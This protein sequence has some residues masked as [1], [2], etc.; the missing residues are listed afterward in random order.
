MFTTTDP[1]MDQLVRVDA[2][3]TD[4]YKEV[5]MQVQCREGRTEGEVA[6]QVQDSRRQLTGSAGQR[7]A[8]HEEY[9]TAATAARNMG[10]LEGLNDDS[11]R[12]EDMT[13][14]ILFRE[15]GFEP[16]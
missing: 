6:A 3:G 12:N 7:E 9:G 15:G 2:S 16:D 1:Y 13:E 4:R 14:V 8:C 10:E 11:L 5:R